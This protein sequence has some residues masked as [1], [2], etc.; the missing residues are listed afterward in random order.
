MIA[1]RKSAERGHAEHGWLD[2]RFT[3]SFAEYHDP[4]FMGF[5][6]LRVINED[7]V[8]PG[9][10][11]P[12]HPHQDME[13]VTYVLEG[14][15]AHKDSMGTSSTIRPGEVQ[16]MTAGTGVRHSEYNPSKS[17][18]LHLF[19]IWILPSQRALTPSYEQKSFPDDQ[20]RGRLRLV[21]SQDGKDGSVTV[22][23]DVS[24]YSTL[25]D[26]GAVV[27][28]ALNAG[29][30]AWIQVTRGAIDLNGTALMAGDGAAVSDETRMEIRGRKAA[31]ILL[32][33]L[34]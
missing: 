18:M 1:V 4:R 12:T 5:R 2:S 29:R 25:L 16:R 14:S 3:F 11:F 23:Q 20:K 15:I 33:D 8:Q 26:E 22:H 7:R 28:H 32:F 17:E 10:G 13:I 19:Q 9:E 24:L 27:K 31:E 34:A 30:H 21:A 6:A